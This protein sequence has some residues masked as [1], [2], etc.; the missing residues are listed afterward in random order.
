MSLRKITRKKA[1]TTYCFE[2]LRSAHDGLW[3]HGFRPESMHSGASETRVLRRLSDGALNYRFVE[4]VR[5]LCKCQVIGYPVEVAAVFGLLNGDCFEEEN[6][7]FHI[8][9]HVDHLPETGSNF[10]LPD[11]KLPPFVQVSQQPAC[12]FHVPHELTS[13]PRQS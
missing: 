11:L 9:A 3:C 4:H 6:F 7:A 10:Q 1:G 8:H 5:S 2:A 12:E 13:N